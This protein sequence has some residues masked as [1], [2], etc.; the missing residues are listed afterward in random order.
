MRMNRLETWMM[1]NPVREAVQRWYAGPLLR[2]LGGTVEGSRVLEIGCGHG[3]GVDIILGQ[4]GAASVDAF[5]LDPDMVARARRRLA[6]HGE[7]VRVWEGSVTEIPAQDGT[8]EAVF[9]FGVLHHLPD[10]RAGLA[11]VRRVLKPGGR[12]F[13]EESYAPFITHPVWRRLLHHP[14]EDRFDHGSLLAELG[15]QHFRVRDQRR[16]GD[17]LGWL[18]ADKA[19]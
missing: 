18:V 15:T 3:V 4:F 7:R 19:D 16:M 10:W 9:A 1:V 11:E 6:R 12:L 17:G 14:Q 8:Y 2:R 13:A 5:D